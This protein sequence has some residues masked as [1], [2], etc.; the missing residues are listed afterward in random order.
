MSA[1]ENVN[2]WADRALSGAFTPG[3]AGGGG[4]SDGEG[5]E[6]GGD[7]TALLAR[8]DGGFGGFTP[9]GGKPRSVDR[10]TWCELSTVARG[11][12]AWGSNA[13]VCA[14]RVRAASEPEAI[15]LPPLPG[16]DSD[17]AAC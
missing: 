1:S 5:V 13:F 2:E 17:A 3:D 6:P 15:A 10:D 7:S 12:T 16:G 14:V 9:S 8:T 11:V 4:T